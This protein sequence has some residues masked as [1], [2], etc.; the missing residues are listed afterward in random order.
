MV[1]AN[2]NKIFVP[3]IPVQLCQGPVDIRG[4]VKSD[5]RSSAEVDSMK[6]PRWM[7]LPR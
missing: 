1:T 3:M 7:S 4:F 6:H 5:N 2:G